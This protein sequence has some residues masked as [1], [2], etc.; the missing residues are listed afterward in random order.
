MVDPCLLTQVCHLLPVFAIAVRSNRLDAAPVLLENIP[1]S[2][3]EFPDFFRRLG[4]Q[5]EKIC[6][7]S[8]V[9]DEREEISRLAQRNGVDPTAY[10]AVDE[11][12]RFLS[13]SHWRVADIANLGAGNAGFACVSLLEEHFRIDHHAV[14]ELFDLLEVPQTQVAETTMPSVVW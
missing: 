3:E 12:A 5:C 11:V 6:H 2:E 9:V 7:S 1:E 8:Y 4:F 10:V 14:D 13:S